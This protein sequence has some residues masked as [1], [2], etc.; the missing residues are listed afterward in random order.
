MSFLIGLAPLYYAISQRLPD[1]V[2]FLLSRGADPNKE[3]NGVPPLAVA[4]ASGQVNC[5]GLFKELKFLRLNW[6][7]YSF[8]MEQI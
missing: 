3:A 1:I 8:N 4:T 5:P 2:E 6:L 7:V